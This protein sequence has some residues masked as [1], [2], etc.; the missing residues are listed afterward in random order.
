[1]R[2]PANY[3]M[4]VS[5]LLFGLVCITFLLSASSYMNLRRM[6]KDMATADI[7]SS[8][9][10]ASFWAMLL[11]GIAVLMFAYLVIYHKPKQVELFQ[12]LGVEEGSCGITCSDGPTSD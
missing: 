2:D 9:R 11:S 10:S 6:P 1:M 5:L 3:N 8:S 12:F 7:V 4:S